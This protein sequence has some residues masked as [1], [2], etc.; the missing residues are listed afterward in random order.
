MDSV[1]TFRESCL[2]TFN[3]SSVQI[4]GLIAKRMHVLLTRL[5]TEQHCFVC[6]PHSLRIMKNKAV[7]REREGESSDRAPFTLQ[8]DAIKPSLQN[9]CHLLPT[10]I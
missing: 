7:Y 5:S 3:P 10:N 1:G 4:K 9:E 2:K 6:S 8:N